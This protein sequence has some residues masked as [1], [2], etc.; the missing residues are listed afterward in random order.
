[1]V[2]DTGPDHGHCASVT[3]SHNNRG[4]ASLLPLPRNS[5]GSSSLFDKLQVITRY[6]VTWIFF[7]T[8][9]NC[10]EFFEQLL[11]KFRIQYFFPRLLPLL[12]L[13]SPFHNTFP[14]SIS[15]FNNTFKQKPSPVRQ[16]H[17][18]H[19]TCT[20]QTFQI[21]PSLSLMVRKNCKPRR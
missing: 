17:R 14:N 2:F 3:I 19:L 12:P 13:N 11:D 15:I 8:L 18:T 21:R 5:K 9:Y 16:P 20:P 1:M 4:M 6:H 10:L 7:Y